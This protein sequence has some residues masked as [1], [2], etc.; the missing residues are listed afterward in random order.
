M[1]GTRDWGLE[2][3]WGLTFYVRQRTS[4]R[5]CVR[6]SV[7]RSVTHSFDDPQGA[8]IGPLGLVLILSLSS[9]FIH[10]RVLRNCPLVC[11]FTA[12]QSACSLQFAVRRCFDYY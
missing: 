9:S 5:G 8:H 2:V 4:I 7:C 12:F 11:S 1:G 6:R 3:G 10:G